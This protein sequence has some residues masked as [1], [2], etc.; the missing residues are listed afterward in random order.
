MSDLDEFLSSAQ[1]AKKLGVTRQ[2]VDQLV[3]EGRL[4]GPVGRVGRQRVWKASDI[5][6]ATA[7]LSTAS[8][9]LP[10]PHWATFPVPQPPL[11]L[12]VDDVMDVP[13]VWFGETPQVHVRIWRGTAAGAPRTVVLY[14]A[15]RESHG[16][17][18]NY[19]E[20]IATAIAATYLG[21]E[22]RR[23]LFFGFWPRGFPRPTMQI[24]YVSFELPRKSGTASGLMDTLLRRGAQEAWRGEFAN[25]VWQPIDRED[26]SRVI[27]SDPDL[28]FPPDTYTAKVVRAL[29]AGRRPTAIEL[30]PLGLAAQLQ[31]LTTLHRYREALLDGSGPS[32]EASRTPALPVLAG[33]KR[34]DALR[35]AEALGIATR[36]MA[37]QAT[38]MLRHYQSQASATPDDPGNAL[39]TRRWYTPTSEEEHALAH[40]ADAL[41]LALDDA[42]ADP[43]SGLSLGDLQRTLTKIRALCD[44]L[45]NAYITGAVP[46]DAQLLDALELAESD[47]SQ[48][49][50]AFDPDLVDD[51]GPAPT[52]LDTPGEPEEGYLAKASW[53][54]PAPGDE[55]RAAQLRDHLWEKD[56]AG[57]RIGYDPFGRMLFHNPE[58]GALIVEKPRRLPQAPYPD[59]AELLAT[60]GNMTVF[61]RLPDGRLDLLPADPRY[62]RYSDF[63]WGY[64]GTGPDNLARAL[65]FALL[66]HPD[67]DH[68]ETLEDRPQAWREFI[69]HLVTEAIP[70]KEPLRLTVGTLRAQLPPSS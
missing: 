28:D 26:L 6:L 59:E 45:A 21:A 54:G 3:A 44:G 29:A 31:R 63:T 69:E 39:V 5:E 58:T 8:A 9:R 68:P 61:V 27:G 33:N 14:G 35:A 49:R 40:N 65:S 38:G 70:Q 20:S 15:I 41:S 56:R 19:A 62:P 16:I 25:P 55:H 36:M 11:A 57:A 32:T 53:W 47:I 18:V 37:G 24:H 42:S 50:L 1:I 13:G 66:D 22:A 2:R 52:L 17:I 12:V 34:E 10:V 4:V 64:G 46:T 48:A 30:D 43:D 23:A 60:P 67:S 7:G 51:P